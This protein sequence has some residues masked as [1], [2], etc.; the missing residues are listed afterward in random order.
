MVTAGSSATTNRATKSDNRY[1][2]TSESDSK[3]FQRVI[4]NKQT[5]VGFKND[6]TLL[7]EKSFLCPP[8]FFFARS[9]VGKLHDLHGSAGTSPPSAQL[10]P[11]TVV[12]DREYGI[13]SMDDMDVVFRGNT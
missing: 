7:Y 12:F 10:W 4:F 8:V 2:S 13:D 3:I 9:P 6:Q 5:G 11:G 1:S